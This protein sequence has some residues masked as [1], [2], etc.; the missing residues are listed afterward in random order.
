MTISEMDARV[1][2]K[3]AWRWTNQSEGQG[4]G[5]HGEFLEVVPGEKL[6]HTQAWGDVGESMGSQPFTVSVEM[7]EVDGVTEVDTLMTFASQQDRDAAY[8][9]GMADGMEMG[10]QRLQE[11]LG[12]M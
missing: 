2:G 5:C 8:S 7:R 3:Y 6:V 10:Y 4:F 1:G 12:G 11:M 9:T